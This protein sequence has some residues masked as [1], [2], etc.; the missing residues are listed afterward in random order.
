MLL[1]MATSACVVATAINCAHPVTCEDIRDCNQL[2]SYFCEC[3][4]G[5]Q[6]TYG[7]D[8]IIS[9]NE[10]VWFRAPFSQMDDGFLSYWYSTGK[11]L[12]EAFP[13]CSLD[14]PALAMVLNGNSS[15]YV[16][17][18]EMLVRLG[19][20]ISLLQNIDIRMRIT[21][22][23]ATPGRVLFF[24][25]SEGAKTSCEAPLPMYSW[26]DHV[27]RDTAA[28]YYLN[29][30]S[31]PQRDGL[32]R[33][34]NP[35]EM[36]VPVGLTVTFGTCDGDTM[37]THL[38]TDS[39][40]PCVLPQQLL[41]SAYRS[42]LPLY[43]H[44]SKPQSKYPAQI[45]YRNDVKYAEQQIDT[46]ICQGKGLAVADT[47]L[48][49]STVFSDSIGANRFKSDSIYVIKYNL[50]IVAEQ[51]K[52]LTL[53]LKGTQFPYRYGINRL[54]GYGDYRFVTHRENECDEAVL[55]HVVP[56][57]TVTRLTR[58][59]V[60]CEGLSVTIG[61][62]T[63][64]TKGTL[65]DTVYSGK[66]LDLQTITTY[67]VR[68]TAPELEYDTISV[69][70]EMM[71]YS[72][73][74]TY[75]DNYGESIVTVRQ[76]DECTKR[77]Q[78]LVRENDGKLTYH[79]VSRDTIG[80]ATEGLQFPDSLL[81]ESTTYVDTIYLNDTLVQI[82]TWNVRI[83][84]PGELQYD[85]IAI[86]ENNMP[87]IYKEQTID[88]YGEYEIEQQVGA[89]LSTLVL[90]VVPRYVVVEVDTTICEGKTLQLADTVISTTTDYVVA[91]PLN[92]HTDQLSV[93]HVMVTPAPVAFDTIT[94]A[95]EDLPLSYA[96]SIITGEGDYLIRFHQTEQCDRVVKLT[97]KTTTAVDNVALTSA[98]INPT[99]ATV[100]QPI[101]LTTG[102]DCRLLVVDALGRQVFN[103]KLNA[104]THTF[105]LDRQ[106]LYVVRVLTETTT[107]TVKIIIGD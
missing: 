52:E 46:V 42:K 55:L 50:Q 53:K 93:W 62:K 60:V 6:V 20:N 9:G 103:A 11:A 92:R 82:T 85:T 16:D 59:T 1:I 57:Y 89:C 86:E 100:G 40:H 70:P 106:G 36:N 83:D 21:P 5:I 43:M 4:R 56:N 8:T 76:K 65:R 34:R 94:V 39:I 102:S 80:C 19:D 49:E 47:V 14:T 98:T 26:N 33:Y 64:T 84:H 15:M 66:Y 29:V 81:W 51:E 25:G 69:H 75:I 45:Y 87:Y 30:T 77:V 96:D 101:C 73:Y 35:R 99:K 105:S 27:F 28:V 67:N 24:A 2:P 58:D 97:V 91:E 88:H 31:K 38:F 13:Y 72:Y 74:G 10:P 95:A 23:D 22:L 107:Q 3:E 61:G 90:E 7:I 41:D 63:L 44:F 54:T 71:P 17:A 48:Y 37:L 78:L 79:R 104:G 32:L 68:F 12:I 18:D